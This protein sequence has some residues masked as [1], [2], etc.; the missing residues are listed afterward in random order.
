MVATPTLWKAKT[1]VNTADAAAPGTQGG[2]SQTLP[3]LAALGDG[4][5]VVVWTDTSRT[6]NPAGS[7]VLGQRYDVWARR[8]EVRSRSVNSIPATSP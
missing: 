2:D 3:L 4:G 1:Q 8:S 6:H 7:A 5:Y